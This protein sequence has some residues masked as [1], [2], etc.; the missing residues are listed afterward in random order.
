MRASSVGNVTF[1]FQSLYWYITGGLF[2][3]STFEVYYK[4]KR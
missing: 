3:V 4:I 2:N 1:D